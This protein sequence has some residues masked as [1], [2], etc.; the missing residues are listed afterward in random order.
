MELLDIYDEKG[1]HIGTEERKIVHQKALWHKT[2]HCWLY[3]KLGNV[4]FQIRKDEKTF[5]TT[6]SGHVSAGETLREAFGREIKEEIGIDI[7]YER[8]E[9]IEVVNFKLDRE[10]KDG[11]MFKDRAFAN[12]FAYK[13]DGI[14]AFNLDPKEVIGIVKVN[15]KEVLDLFK[16]GSGKISA[17]IINLDNTIT[18]RLVDFNE[19]LVNKKETAIGKYGK[20]LE[21]VI[22]KNLEYLKDFIKEKYAGQTRKQGTPYYEH[23]ILVAEILKEK[24]FDYDYYVTALFHDL[25]EDTNATEKEIK[26]LSN[27][28]ILNAVKLLTK[29]KRYVIENYISNIN[30][31]KLAKMV[32][33]SDRLHNL[34]E[35]VYADKNWRLKYIK[36]TEKY[37]L[38]LAE[39]TPFEKDINNALEE[40][41][42]SL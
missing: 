41:I 21:F 42:K 10:N 11:T 13:I 6:A 23:P 7:D 17:E 35:G 33:L 18:K 40:L 9:L 29:E 37:F 24:G 26:N 4:Y 31:N 38:P 27:N 1:N 2:V 20:V 12:V 34:K 3:D 32:K 5:Y 15:A 16:K 36:E 22:N 14:L 39:G 25:L 19:F 8:A 30:R 28:N